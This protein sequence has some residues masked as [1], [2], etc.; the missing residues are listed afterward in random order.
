MKKKYL[1]SL[2]FSATLLV[3]LAS[4]S[5]ESTIESSKRQIY[6]DKEEVLVDKIVAFDWFEYQ[7]NDAFFA[8]K[9]PEGQFQNPIVAGF[10]PDPS[11]T[12]KGDDYYMAVSSFSYTPGVPF[13]NGN[14][15]W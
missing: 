7:G 3:N 4:C 11:I 10:Y 12:R 9:L 2:L 6:N 1:I 13:G 15:T 14:M 5:D 8:D